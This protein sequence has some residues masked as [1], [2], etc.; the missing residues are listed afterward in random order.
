MIQNGQLTPESFV[1]KAGMANWVKAAEMPEVSSMF[2]AT[3][4]PPPPPPVG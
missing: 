3:P 1:W 2:G 4:P